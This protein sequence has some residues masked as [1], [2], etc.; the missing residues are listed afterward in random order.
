V[1][2]RGYTR[3]RGPLR[4]ESAQRLVNMLRTQ[5]VEAVAV[6]ENPPANAILGGFQIGEFYLYAP[7]AEAELARG[8][9]QPED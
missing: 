7:D 8:L 6:P 3:L 2:T 9:L 4:L 5:G 1:D